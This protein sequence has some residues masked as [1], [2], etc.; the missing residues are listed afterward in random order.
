MAM[1]VQ[2]SLQN[3]VSAMRK[4]LN[5]EW[6]S[7]TGATFKILI[8]PRLE[9]LCVC[10]VGDIMWRH[11]AF[12][13]KNALM[14][15]CDDS[16]QHLWLGMKGISSGFPVP[17]RTAVNM[18]DLRASAFF[19][20]IKDVLADANKLNWYAG[21]DWQKTRPVHSWVRSGCTSG[22]SVQAV[23]KQNVEEN[24]ALRS[25]NACRSFLPP[26]ILGPPPGLDP[27]PNFV[28]RLDHHIEKLENTC[29]KHTSPKCGR[30]N[31]HSESD[32]CIGSSASD[33]D[34]DED[35]M[36]PQS[37]TGMPHGDAPR[38]KL[39]LDASCFVPRPCLD[40]KLERELGF[41]AKLRSDGMGGACGNDNGPSTSSIR[42]IPSTSDS[43]VVKEDNDIVDNAFQPNV[44][45]QVKHMQRTKLRPGARKFVPVTVAW[46]QW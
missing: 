37:V 21:T 29:T 27:P 11:D 16:C 5:G 44:G 7:A 40:V 42:G 18:K 9:A 17:G 24:V 31:A 25:A 19:A 34:T 28:L 22:V 46:Q 4:A 41:T 20:D 12:A 26:S 15:W 1:L 45:T 23:T 2:G 14:L 30:Q 6:R 33:C 35:N 10:T 38:T 32:T 8:G 13:S 36:G 39:R 43:N 3:D